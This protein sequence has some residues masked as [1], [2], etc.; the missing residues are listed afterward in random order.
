MYRVLRPGGTLAAGV[1]AGPHEQHRGSCSPRIARIWETCLHPFARGLSA[2]RVGSSSAERACFQVESL[3]TETHPS[4]GITSLTHWGDPLPRP[5]AR[6]DAQLQPYCDPNGSS[7]TSFPCCF[8]FQ[9]S[10][11]KR[12]GIV[13]WRVGCLRGNGGADRCTRSG[14]IKRVQDGCAVRQ[15]DTLTVGSEWHSL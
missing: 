5:G 1:W 12:K 8:F 3:S 13:P 7:L 15:N 11:S 2:G 4:I 14:G 9:V 10:E 6:R